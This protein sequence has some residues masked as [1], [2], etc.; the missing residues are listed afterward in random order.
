MLPGV[1]LYSQWRHNDGA[2][3]FQPIRNVMS[4][5]RSVIDRPPFLGPEKSHQ[6]LGP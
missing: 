5:R 3:G 6:D 2:C 1:K 4:K